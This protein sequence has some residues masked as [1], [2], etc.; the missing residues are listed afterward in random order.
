MSEQMIKKASLVIAA[1]AALVLTATVASAAGGGGPALKTQKWSFNGPT[2][3]YDRAQV[4]RG[5][6]VYSEVCAGCH[7]LKYVRFGNLPA[8]GFSEAQA[9]AIA[10]EFEAED[11]PDDDGE[12]YMR[13]ARLSDTLPSPFAND[14]AARASNNGALPPDLSLMAKARVGGADYIYSLLTGYSDAPEGHEVAEGMNY[15]AWFP[16]TQIA[17]APPV[18]DDGVEYVDG[19]AATADQQ[20]KDVSAF[21]MW[22]AEPKLEDR[23]RIGLKTMIF[24][25]ILTGLFWL[26]K[27]RVWADAH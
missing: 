21:L 9:K 12:M 8:I 18:S 5:Y 1:T 24:L 13:P 14:K 20:A 3:T 25:I 6:Q 11:G 23:H 2:G 26:V 16:G 22:A 27:R 15:N 19:T 7:S 17:M 10:A 4:Q